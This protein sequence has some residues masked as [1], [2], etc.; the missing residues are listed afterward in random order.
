M[1]VQI[2]EFGYPCYAFHEGGPE[3]GEQGEQ[4]ATY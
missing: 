1:L 2:G 3:Q 4:R